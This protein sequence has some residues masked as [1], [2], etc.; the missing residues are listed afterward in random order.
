M[1]KDISIGEKANC[2]SYIEDTKDINDVKQGLEKLR[3]ELHEKNE[4]KT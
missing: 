3:R 1:G 2:L 4:S